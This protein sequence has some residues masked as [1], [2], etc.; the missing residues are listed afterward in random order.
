[1]AQKSWNDSATACHDMGAQLV[2]IKSDEEQ[3]WV[4]LVRPSPQ[5]RMHQGHGLKGG[6]VFGWIQCSGKEAAC[7]K[8]K[9]KRLWMRPEHLQKDTLWG[10]KGGSVGNTLASK[11]EDLSLD[12]SN[13][14]KAQHEEIHL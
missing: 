12:S 9:D 2:V 11:H 7:L 1:M 10:W 4:C 5:L 6:K 13:P 14:H 8:R 3:V